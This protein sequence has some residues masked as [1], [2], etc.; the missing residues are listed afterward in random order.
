[1]LLLVR[2]SRARLARRN[3]TEY[4]EVS[5]I[6]QR[7][8]GSLR[9]QRNL[10]LIPFCKLLLL[11]SSGCTCMFSFCDILDD[12]DPYLISQIFFDDSGYGSLPLV[13]DPPSAE[14]F[15]QKSVL[16]LTENWA[17]DAARRAWAFSRKQG[18]VS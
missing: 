8:L 6:L 9:L 14:D 18:C 3:I 7:F 17:A 10:P 11:C 13:D 16:G 2:V 1:M 4:R 5:G 15:A 12:F